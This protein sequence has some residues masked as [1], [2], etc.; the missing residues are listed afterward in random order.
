M[1]ILIESVK[2]YNYNEI[3]NKYYRKPLIKYLQLP[4]YSRVSVNIMQT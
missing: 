4:N 2:K 1:Y 3:S